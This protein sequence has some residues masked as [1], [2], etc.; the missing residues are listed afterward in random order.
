[1]IKDRKELS[2]KTEGDERTL[3]VLLKHE[4]KLLLN[5]KQTLL[6]HGLRIKRLKATKRSN[7]IKIHRPRRSNHF[8]VCQV[9]TAFHV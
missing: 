1:M 3:L 8:N 2:I 4:N 9:S 6:V 5:C 7:Y